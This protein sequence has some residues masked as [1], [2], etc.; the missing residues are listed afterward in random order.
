VSLKKDKVGAVMVVGGGIG[1]VQASL[2]LAESGFKVYLVEKSLSIGGVMAQL[3]K[4]FPT[5]DCA[6]CIL[7]PKL[8]DCGR[9]RNVEMLTNS[10]VESIEGEVGNFKVRVKKHSRFVDLAKCTGCGDCAEVCP[11][12]IPSEY[13]E[14]LVNR[15]AIYRPF[16]QATPNAFGIEKRGISPCRAACPL[17]VNAQGYIALI[18]QGK[19][20]EALTLVREKNP[21]PGICGRV[22]THPCEGECPRQNVD[23]PI[24]IDLL[25]RFVADYDREVDFELK[26]EQEKE[27]RIAIIGSGPAGLTSAYDLRKMGYKPTIFEA[28]PVAGGML[29]VGIPDYRLPKDILRKEISILE[30]F[31]IEIKLNTP[32]GENLTIEELKN[33]GYEAIFIAVGAHISMKLEIPGEDLK[34]VYHGVEFLRRVNLGEKVEVGEKVVV[35]GGGNAAIDAARTVYRL[36][37]K[38]VTIV[39][40]RSRAEMP[41]NEEEIEEAEKEGI[42]IFYLAAPTRILGKESKVNQVQ[43][44]RMRLGEPDASGRRRPIPIEGSEFIIDADMIIPA[45]GQSSD[46]SFLGS[47]HKFNLVRGRGFEVDPLTLETN[48]K[49]IFAGGDTVTGPDTVIEAMA[50]GRKA[51]ISIDRYLNGEDMRVGRE[52]EGS[53]ESEIEVDTE[54]VEP[55][56]RTEVAALPVSERKGNFKEVI[57]GFSEEEIIKE[58][59]RCLACGGCSECMQCV[60][61]CKAEAVL[62]DMLEEDREIKVGSVIL[63]P[64]FDEF[65]PQ[66]KEEYGYKRFPN[67]VS[68]IEFE[69]ILSASGPYQGQV[70]RMS[71]DKHPKSIAWIQCVGSRDSKIKRGYCSSVCCMYSTK[72]ALIT[73]EHAPDTETS[74]FYMDM[75]AYGK[76]FDK[77]IKRAESEYGVR[78]VRSRISEVEEDLKTHNLRIQYETDDGKLASEEFEMVVLSVG[79]E[80]SKSAKEIAEKFNIQLNSYN[81]AKTSTFKPLQTSRPGIFVG[82][83]FSG[84][85]D[86]PET[87]AQASGVAAEASSILSEARGSL[88]REKEYPPEIEVS[89]E[90]PRIGVFVCHCGINIGGVVDVPS[91]VEWVKTLPSVVYAEG[92]LYTCSQDTQ[93]RIKGAV[94]EHQLN[95]IV[96]ASCT[97]R[98]HEPLFQET[99]REAGLNRYLFEMANIRDQC[100]WIHMR[101]PEKATKK[102]KD[103]VRMAVAKARLIEPLKRLPLD[104]TPRGLVIGGG[105]SGMTS[106]LR[107]AE[108]GYEVYLVEKERELGGQAKD[109]HYTLEGEDVQKFLGKLI[110]KVKSNDRI[111]LFTGA[112]IENIEGFVGNFKTTVKID[113]SIKELEHGIIIVATGAKEYQPTEYLYGKERGVVTQREL[114]KLMVNGKLEVNTQNSMV[115]IQCVGSRNDKHP[116]CSRICCSEAIKNA[117]KIKQLNKKANIYILYRDMRT[118]GFKEDYYQRAREEGVIFIRYEEGQE[119]EVKK[120]KEKLEVL[121][122][123]LILKENLL[124]NADLVVLSTGVISSEDG[125]EL[126]QMLKVPLNEDGFFLEAHVKLRPVDFAT[127]GIFLCGLAHSPKFI[128]ESISQ[129]NAAISRACTIL[130]KDKILAEGT[131]VSVNE[132][133]CNGCGICEAV[134]IYNAIEIDKEKRVAKVNEALCKGCGTCTGACF[135]GAINQRGF[136]REQ[137]LAMTKAALEVGDERIR[138]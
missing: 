63:F 37:A 125:E 138:T 106:A 86:I 9:H 88:V 90:A 7:S 8:V 13:E 64:G 68:S 91:I 50:A 134:C 122:K 100:S 3:D 109:I 21:L 49:G 67:V 112:K 128:E 96:V 107:L 135:S 23:E 80:A 36:G 127:E 118:Y 65:N 71:D 105:V 43:C 92:N 108:E 10:E 117:L 20:K 39:Y 34:G 131:V 59:K 102:A 56:K 61:A 32:L 78:Y 19:F 77:Y 12:E 114:E 26:I 27:N 103:L 132:D 5:N 87:V 101:E 115:M 74:I 22:C 33:N 16:T 121:V 84:P 97:P 62:H 17:Q 45:L 52:G 82:G 11:V 25:K 48:L 57:L 93:E 69:R 54:G 120:G 85:K 53:Q 66:L 116:Y 104:V 126:A 76:D 29:R 75:R 35:V 95:R 42:K 31:G 70:T 40:R 60:E 18:S 94:K 46:L 44:I 133:R 2:D 73:K 99:I 136:K 30:D 58:A 83:A 14:N 38:E 47:H 130:A 129:A 110:A 15:K 89:G 98:T 55:K 111:R 119:P 113:S 124:I 81:F 137:I 4:T 6:M 41:A 123:D 1:G 72:E 79:L 51:A 24:A 28:L